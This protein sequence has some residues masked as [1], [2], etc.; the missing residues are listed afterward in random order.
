MFETTF[1]I[2]DKVYSVQKE[3]GAGGFA[4]VFSAIEKKSGQVY[5]VKRITYNSNREKERVQ[6]EIRIFETFRRR[7]HILNLH[8]YSFQPSIT[9]N[10][11]DCYLVLDYIS[12]GSLFDYITLFEGKKQHIAENVILKIV[13]GVCLALKQLHDSDPPIAHRDIKPHNVLLGND[14]SPIL[15]DF[16]SCCVVSSLKAEAKS[17]QELQENVNETTTQAYCPPELYDY[18]GVMDDNV[19]DQRVDIWAVGCLLYH[20]AFYLNPFDRELVKRGGS[21]KLAIHNAKFSFDADSPYSQRFHQLIK[22]L[23]VSNASERPFIDGVIE[24]IE[25]N[26]QD[27][28]LKMEI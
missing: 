9:E 4:K 7:P 18:G 10:C 11:E 14:L 23:I 12:G 15:T 28:V 21:M 1:E 26:L 17:K 27:T 25:T 3:I 16:G 2:N 22:T 19:V 6:Q 5:A 20:C 24:L 8:E 13:H